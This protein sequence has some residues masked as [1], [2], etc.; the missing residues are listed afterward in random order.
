MEAGMSEGTV[1]EKAVRESSGTAAGREASGPKQ[2]PLETDFGK[3]EEN[4]AAYARR[5][6]EIPA[7][8][9]RSYSPLT[10][11]FLG[12]AVYEL[13][14]RTMV[15]TRANTSPNQLNRQS[16]A[17]VKA[18][19]QAQMMHAI[20]GQLREA[21]QAIYKRGRNAHSATKA[22]NATVADYRTATGFEALVGY[23]YL[24]GDLRRVVELV[25]AGLDGRTK[26]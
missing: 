24:K 23:L 16:S 3:T 12:D 25:R 8:D 10:L 1:R 21:E 6:L 20:A 2:T 15:V 18:A 4:L 13:V 26:K 14:I 22:K 17:L 11:A 5:L 7:F 19:A 9:L